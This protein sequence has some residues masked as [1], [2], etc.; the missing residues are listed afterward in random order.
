MY[1]IHCLLRWRHESTT[2]GG[3]TWGTYHNIVTV[4]LLHHWKKLILAIPYSNGGLHTRNSDCYLEEI[5]EN[6]R[7]PKPATGSPTVLFLN[8]HYRAHLCQMLQYNITRHTNSS[9]TTVD[10][11]CFFKLDTLWCTDASTTDTR[12]T[13]TVTVSSNVYPLLPTHSVRWQGSK[14]CPR[15]RQSEQNMGAAIQ[16][17]G[18]LSRAAGIMITLAWANMP[19]W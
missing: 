6:L 10:S 11:S 2:V 8:Q 14:R 5:L 19:I 13:A 7:H 18:R 15:W 12:T 16:L 17:P 4:T 3:P 9:K 1:L